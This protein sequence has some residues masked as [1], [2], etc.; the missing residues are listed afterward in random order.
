MPRE[1]G[2]TYEKCRMSQPLRNG[3]DIKLLHVALGS[4]VGVG[5]KGPDEVL[6]AALSALAVAF[7]TPVQQSRFFS[8]PAYP[9]G[10]GPDFVNAVV[11]IPTE[12]SA[13]AALGHLHAIEARFK[14]DR[15][16]RWQPRTLDLDLLAAGQQV[17]PD[18]ATF[19]EWF[20]L[21]PAEQQLKAPDGLIL[22]HPRLH[23]RAFVLVPFHDVAPQWR[24]P[25]TGKSV[26][27]MLKA[28]PA[29]E[30]AQIRPL[31][32][33]NKPERDAS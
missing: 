13:R 30:I 1:T 19:S 32:R 23:E 26:A 17:L 20:S 9:P 7:E 16:E 8:T 6:E 4:N 11:A 5:G 22:P 10:S 33:D 18:G 25:V 14:R 31:E 27:E 15:A 28:L 29:S 3:T 24:H 21:D 2:P 12:M